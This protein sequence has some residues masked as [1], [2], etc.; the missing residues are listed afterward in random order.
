MEIEGFRAKNN[1]HIAFVK[2]SSKIF[3]LGINGKNLETI[4]DIT[5]NLSFLARYH[6]HFR[7]A[8]TTFPSC[9]HDRLVLLPLPCLYDRQSTVH[10]QSTYRPSYH[11]RHLIYRYGPF[12][13]NRRLCNGT[14]RD[15]NGRMDG[16]WT[17]GKIFK[18]SFKNAVI[19]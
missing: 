4:F 7:L 14:R 2:E 18:L 12:V 3:W 10:L 17:V 1:P 13:C 16:R 19:L 9:F 11:Y 15:G 8:S 5:V 6:Y